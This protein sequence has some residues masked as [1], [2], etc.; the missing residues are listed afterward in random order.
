MSMD[1]ASMELLFDNPTA[2]AMVNGWAKCK[3]ERGEGK[4]GAALVARW[5]RVSGVDPQAIRT[6]ETM[7]F[8]HEICL[9]DGTVDPVAMAYLRR[10]SLARLPKELRQQAAA[11][12]AKEAP[13]AG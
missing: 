7:L 12:P 13:S 9:P 6:W 1:I 5:A 2:R 10:S 11:K 3:R 8:A 4:I